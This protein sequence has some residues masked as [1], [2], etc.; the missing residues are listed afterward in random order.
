MPATKQ[1]RKSNAKKQVRTVT[2][3]EILGRSATSVLKWMG[4]RGFS[5]ADAQKVVAK[6][7]SDEIKPS[8]IATAL[9][10]GKN[11]KYNAGMAKLTRDEV[12]QIK[13]IVSR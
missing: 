1:A 11:P 12:K 10:D 5:T 13:G 3:V 8:T 9:S 7:A 6:L 2:R 4:D